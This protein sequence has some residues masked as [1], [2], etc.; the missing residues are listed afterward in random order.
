[1]GAS[2]DPAKFSKLL[3]SIENYIQKT[4]KKPDDIVKA[5]QKLKQPMLDYPR[6]PKKSECMDDDGDIN[7][8]AFKLAKFEWKEEYKVMKERKDQFKDNESNGAHLRPFH[9]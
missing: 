9:T 5:I 2:S 7:D 3:K 6:Q 1:M 4:Y 8:N